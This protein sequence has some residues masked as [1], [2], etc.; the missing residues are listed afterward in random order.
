M[1]KRIE[2]L[3]KSMLGKLFV[4]FLTSLVFLLSNAEFYHYHYTASSGNYS[5]EVSF[6]QSSDTGKTAKH[7][8]D[9]CLICQ[10][11]QMHILFCNFGG[12]F[13]LFLSVSI[14]ISA[15]NIV[16]RRSVVISNLH[17]RAPPATLL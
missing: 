15:F 9:I 2:R 16:K 8:A 17:L 11:I 1:N 3:N 4:V 7:I 12:V 13:H 14:V 6:Q 10:L 5:Q